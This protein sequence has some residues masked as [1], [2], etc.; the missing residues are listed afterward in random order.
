MGISASWYG[1]AAP[2][3]WLNVANGFYVVKNMPCR[4]HRNW[5]SL[6]LLMVIDHWGNLWPKFWPNFE[7]MKAHWIDVQEGLMIQGMVIMDKKTSAEMQARPEFQASPKLKWALKIQDSFLWRTGESN[8]WPLACH[9]SAL[10]NWAS[11]P[12]FLK[13]VFFYLLFGI[14]ELINLIHQGLAC[15]PYIPEYL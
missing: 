10:A 12:L 4:L 11:S 7:L 1:W 13:N 8:P 2:C 6:K 14:F 5:T 15:D 9:A 3:C